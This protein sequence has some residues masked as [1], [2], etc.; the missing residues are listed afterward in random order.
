MSILCSYGCN[1]PGLF[2]S[3]RGIYRCA[4]FSVSCPVQ[5]QKR[6]QKTKGVKRRPESAEKRRRTLKEKYGVINPSQ[7][8]GIMQ[9]KKATWLKNWGVDNPSKSPDIIDKI[10]QAWPTIG[11]KRTETNIQKY[12][13]SSYSNTEEFLTRRKSTWLKKYGVD[14]PAKHD[15]VK[16][17]IQ[18]GQRYKSTNK[19]ILLNGVNVN[20]QGYEPTV[21]A[22]LI[23]S[24]IAEKDIVVARNLVPKITYT[25][26]GKVR[27]Y[28]P[29]IYIPRYN[30]LIEVKSLY[31][32]Q[33]YKDTNL[34]KFHAAKAAGYVVRI[35]IRT[36]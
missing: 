32:W 11:V 13:V 26:R 23:K 3:V 17:K 21:I 4:Q 16:D 24:G 31:T 19:S 34:A 30:M 35:M 6:S 27:R 18:I 15:S 20:L 28:Y 10:K 2:K 12:G 25:F 5:K 22:D 9:K 7:I 1:Q 29:D 33:K 36:C 14:N 8:P